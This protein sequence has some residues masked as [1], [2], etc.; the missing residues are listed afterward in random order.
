LIG[1]VVAAETW[2]LKGLAQKVNME[3]LLVAV[4]I[5]FEGF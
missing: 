4:A 1:T 2:E 3:D 5:L